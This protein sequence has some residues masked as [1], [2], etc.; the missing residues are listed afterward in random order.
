[1][2]GKKIYCFIL[3]MVCM[4]FQLAAQKAKYADIAAGYDIKIPENTGASIHVWSA[5]VKQSYIV[6]SNTILTL[7]VFSHDM[8]LMAEKKVPLGKIKS[9]NMD[10]KY[11]DTCYYAHIFYISDTHNRLILKIDHHGN[12]QDVSDTYGPWARPDS[13]RQK[14]KLYAISGKNNTL[15]LIK[16]ENI[17]TSASMEANNIKLLGGENFKA[18]KTIQKLII[19]KVNIKSREELQR[20]YASSSVNFTYPFI[21]VTDTGVLAYSLAEPESKGDR[22]N[23]YNGSFLFLARLDTNLNESGKGPAMLKIST[24]ARAEKYSPSYLF[25]IN[26]KLFFIYTGWETNEYYRYPPA[27]PNGIINYIPQIFN[28]ILINSLRIIVINEKNNLCQ[29]TSIENRPGNAGL[30]LS[31]PFVIASGKKID[32]FF[33]RQYHGSKNGITHMS[34]DGDGN[35]KEEDMIVDVHYDYL[36]PKAIKL[37]GGVLVI[38]YARRGRTTGIMKLAYEQDDS[39]Q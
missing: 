7:Q 27:N 12:V 10:F 2:P 26:N 25:S 39:P 11:L 9:W 5:S 31:N 16:T 32:F 38:P 1:M 4:E 3:L 20:I 30:D 34:I 33:S 28:T 24:A 21:N 36:L 6:A 15:F 17:D 18:G 37:T 19:K 22:R 13:S 35:M 29:D 8:N 23:P 14:N